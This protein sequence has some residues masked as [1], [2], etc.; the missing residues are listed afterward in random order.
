MLIMGAD[1][2]NAINQDDTEN[3]SFLNSA[4][5]AVGAGFNSIAD[6]SSITNLSELF[7]EDPATGKI[8]WAAN[9]ADTV[10]DIP[11]ELIPTLMGAVTRTMDQNYHVAYDPNSAVKT[12]LNEA[13]AKIPFLS[14]TLPVSH[15]TW[16]NERKRSDSVGEA[17][18]AQLINPGQ[19][20]N[21]NIQPMDSE[22][23][24][25]N[26]ATGDNRVF[27]AK[28]AWNVDGKHLTNQEYSEYQKALG[29]RSSELVS[30]LQ[31]SDF[32]KELPDDMRVETLNDMYLFAN[33]L[34][35]SE[36]FGYDIS[37]S[38]TYKKMYEVYSESGVDGLIDYCAD[39]EAASNLGMQYDTYKKKQSEYAGGAEQ[40]ATDKQTAIDMGF[41]DKEGNAN[42]DAYQKA[43]N[44]FG[45]DSRYIQQ[46]A[47]LDSKAQAQ[48]GKSFSG[49]KLEQKIPMLEGM[50]ISNAEKGKYLAAASGDMGKKA[51]AVYNQYG[52]EGYYLYY[53][54]KSNKDD[55]D[56]NGN[57]KVT[58]DERESY[59]RQMGLANEMAAFLA[60]Q[61]F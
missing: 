25:L 46:Y 22:L 52:P 4:K 38:N 26:E 48:Y 23:I 37:E 30:A 1:I 61:G 28:A 8:N 54:G 10:L 51:T 44:A 24:R 15:D 5:N 29:T 16:G 42:L 55:M 11:S 13:K 34:T 50:N 47:N 19:L 21:S 32:Y 33:A 20:S 27:P 18:F 39:K 58:K 43:Q 35:K 56:Y 40:Y 41:V 2:M 45:G 53:L 3:Y 59:F 12:K 7:A 9:I 31:G 6:Q 49:A 14:Q 17:A 57:G 60:K 36:Q